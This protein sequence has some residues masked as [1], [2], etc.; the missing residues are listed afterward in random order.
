MKFPSIVLLVLA[1]FFCASC[2]YT[3]AVSQTN[4]PEN[5]SKPVEAVEKKFIVLGFNFDNDYVFKLVDELKSKC[6]QGDVRGIMT[7]DMRTLYFLDFFWSREIVA[8]GYCVPH[9]SLIGG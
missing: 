7:Q 3:M 4:I 2:T 6:P 8:K 5:R 9:Q 1:S